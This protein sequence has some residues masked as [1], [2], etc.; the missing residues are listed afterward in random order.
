[1]DSSYPYRDTQEN[2][3]GSGIQVQLFWGGDIEKELFDWQKEGTASAKALRWEQTE[4]E[5]WRVAM[6]PW[7]SKS[8]RPGHSGVIWARALNF[9][10]KSMKPLE[11]FKQKWDWMYLVFAELGTWLLL[12]LL[13]KLDHQ[14]TKHHTGRAG[15]LDYAPR[16][17]GVNTYSSEAGTKGLQSFYR[18]CMTSDFSGQCWLIIGSFK[19][20]VLCNGEQ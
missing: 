9:I 6:W 13:Q 16:T 2:V 1:M 10:L 15:E 18:Q 11:H 8:Q 20:A 14:E 4:L 7:Q 19:L 3:F 5:N 17:R 12:H